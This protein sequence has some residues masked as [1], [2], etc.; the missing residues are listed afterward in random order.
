M[1]PVEEAGRAAVRRH[2]RRL[3]IG[4]LAVGT[5]LLLL[6]VAGRLGLAAGEI[7]AEA[8]L[9]AGQVSPW[10][11]DLLVFVFAAG[12]AQLTAMLRAIERGSLFDAAVVRHFRAFAG[13]LLVAAII[14]LIIPIAGTLLNGV[15]GRYEF[16]ISI[17]DLMGVAITL[18]LFLVAGLLERARELEQEMQEIL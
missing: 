4:V 11:G 5:L 14:S 1:N 3:R 8:R 6:Y 12:V 15:G 9:S 10:F 2:A 17:R 7:K 16:R 18:L 13:W